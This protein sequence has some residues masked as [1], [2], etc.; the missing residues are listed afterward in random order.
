[1]TP[2][3]RRLR[4]TPGAPVDLQPRRLPEAYAE[5]LQRC[6][7][8]DAPWY[9]VPADRKWYSR[10]AVAMVVAETLE[11]MDPQLPRPDLDVRA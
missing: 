4:L 5:A 3:T 10:Y 7:S 2:L 1:M 6:S 8:E 11:R 9:V